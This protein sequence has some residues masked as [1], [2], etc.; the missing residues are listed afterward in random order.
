[1]STD[2]IELDAAC[3]NAGIVVQTLTPGEAVL[4]MTV[5]D[6]MLNLHGIAHGG[7]VFLLADAAFA[8]AANHGGR[9]AVAQSAQITYLRAAEAAEV[10]EAHAIERGRSGRSALYD[11]T[12]RGRDASVVAEFRGQCQFVRSAPA[13][14]AAGTATPVEPAHRQ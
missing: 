14:G 3:R 8:Y 5:D 9:T 10:L 1:M 12:V 4:R 2:A 7:V 6:R 13:P 11:V